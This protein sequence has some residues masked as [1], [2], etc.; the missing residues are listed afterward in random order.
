MDKLV[1]TPN[2]KYKSGIRN[3]AILAVLSYAGLRVSELINLKLADIKKKDSTIR[4]NNTKRG[5]FR[6]VYVPGYLFLYIDRYLK[7]KPKSRY[8]FCSRYGNRLLPDY[9]QK[10]VKRYAKKVDKNKDIHPHAL[11]HSIATIWLKEGKPIRGIQK[12]LGHKNLATTQIYMDYF[13]DD[14]KKD[15]SKVEKF[16][17]KE[18]KERI[19]WLQEEVQKLKECRLKF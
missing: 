4:V 17:E 19:E 13:D 11:R 18:L 8:L 12:Q 6:M 16:G 14:R 7:A 15:F 2:T 9:I 1:N 5:S 3:R 10:M